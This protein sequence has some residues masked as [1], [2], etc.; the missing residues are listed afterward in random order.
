MSLHLLIQ[1]NMISPP[2]K[3]AFCVGVSTLWYHGQISLDEML[4]AI[5]I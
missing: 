4:A 1:N 3:L 5:A 2:Q